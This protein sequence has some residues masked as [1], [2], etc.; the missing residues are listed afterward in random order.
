MKNF[1]AA[2]PNKKYF[3]QPGM[4]VEADIAVDYRRLY[5]WMFQPIIEVNDTIKTRL[6]K[7][8]S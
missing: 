5:Q 8:N 1:I 6:T 2:Y 7:P 4:Q 3:L